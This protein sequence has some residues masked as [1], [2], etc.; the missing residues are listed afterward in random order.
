M[1]QVK[2]IIPSERIAT[3]IHVFH[4]EKVMLD[5][6][7]AELYGVET[8]VLVRAVKRN[9]KRFPDDFMFQ[10]TKAEFDVLLRFQ[11]GTSKTEGRGGVLPPLS[12]K[13]YHLTHLKRAG[14][15][16][17]QRSTELFTRFSTPKPY[18]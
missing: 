16:R 8:K 6:D 5:R 18:A 15:I 10:L 1:K 11:F 2:D 13:G 14:Y 9:I 7:L 17:F 3:M 12:V 4:G